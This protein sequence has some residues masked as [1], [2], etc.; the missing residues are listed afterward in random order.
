M[1]LHLEKVTISHDNLLKIQI[2]G[3]FRTAPFLFVSL[4]YVLV[5]LY[6]RHE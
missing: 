2:W 4:N 5:R 1:A 3:S 6:I